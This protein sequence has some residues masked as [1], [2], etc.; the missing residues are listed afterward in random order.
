MDE[1]ARGGMAPQRADMPPTP[2]R[3]V[4]LT[5]ARAYLGNMS[6]TKFRALM[7]NGLEYVRL[8]R[9]I[10]FRQEALDA[11]VRDHTVT[12]ERAS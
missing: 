2:R 4:T 8:G 9:R 12:P 11:L 3:L 6:E 10:L 1:T 7:M 5:E